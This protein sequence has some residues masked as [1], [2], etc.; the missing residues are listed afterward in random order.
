MRTTIAL[1]G[2]TRD[3][4]VALQERWG[5]P[6]VEA[7]LLRLLAGEPQTA[8]AL[9]AARKKQVDEVLARHR[10]QKLVA[11]GSRARG[12]A[13]PDS[14]LDLAGSLPRGA[15]LIDVVHLKEDL[16]EAFGV[17]VDFVSLSGARP[18][19]RQRIEQEGVRLVG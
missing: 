14:D 17:P 5:L 16:Q 7:V 2:S 12:D 4:L 13:R 3:R 10:V 8:E 1:D 6:N 18:R 19:L 11:F 15:D 9:Y